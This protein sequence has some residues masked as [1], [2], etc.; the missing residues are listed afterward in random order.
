MKKVTVVAAEETN[1]ERVWQM[2]LTAESSAYQT[3]GSQH[4]L[5]QLQK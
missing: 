3:L 4:Y 5:M 1:K 2:A